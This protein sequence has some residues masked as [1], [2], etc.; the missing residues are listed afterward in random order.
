[1]YPM[2]EPLGFA[3][4]LYICLAALAGFQMALAAD[5]LLLKFLL[6]IMRSGVSQ[7]YPDSDP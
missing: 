1:M 7:K 6:R 4:T 3:D 2:G 5:Y